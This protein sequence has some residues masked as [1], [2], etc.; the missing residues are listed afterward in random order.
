MYCSAF[1]CNVNCC[2]SSFLIL[3]GQFCFISKMTCCY[4]CNTFRGVFLL[5]FNCKG[6]LFYNV[7]PHQPIYTEMCVRCVFVRCFSI[8]ISHFVY[9]KRWFTLDYWWCV[10]DAI[11]S[12]IHLFGLFCASLGIFCWLV[13]CL[14]LNYKHTHPARCGSYFHLSRII[15]NI[16]W[17]GI[18]QII[19]V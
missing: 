7:S 15:P 8:E 12:I 18:S 9:T 3:G 5:F 14:S 4:R 2:A 1:L 13:C 11:Y 19:F 10:V 17:L 6:H 16:L